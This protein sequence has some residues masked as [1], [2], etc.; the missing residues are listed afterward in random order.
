MTLNDVQHNKIYECKV[1]QH[2]APVHIVDV[3]PTGVLGTN[4]DT[5]REVFIKKE[6]L[7]RIGKLIENLSEWRL[8][9][10]D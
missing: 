10:G 1:G 5:N 8:H 6:Q 9:N 4:L 7:S 3:L 2:M